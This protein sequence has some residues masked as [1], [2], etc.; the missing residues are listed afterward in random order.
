MPRQPKNPKFINWRGSEV[1]KLILSDLEDGRLPIKESEMSA[2]D[3]WEIYKAA[4]LPEFEGV[5]FDQFRDR[6]KDHRDQVRKKNEQSVWEVSAL[7]HDLTLH[8]RN[9]THDRRGKPIFDRSPAKDLLRQ[10]IKEGVY[11]SLTPMELWSSRPE[12]RE[13]ELSVFRGRIYQEI[14][15]TKFL[16]WCQLKREK[17][18]AEKK[19]RN[20]KFK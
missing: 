14:R 2:E 7:M 17:K 15:R 9:E 20:Y 12:Y 16:N 4:N 18:E 1:R 13:F 19:E 8:P 10:D 11:P 6:L 3:A 5:C